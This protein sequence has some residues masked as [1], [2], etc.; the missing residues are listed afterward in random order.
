MGVKCLVVEQLYC[1]K[2]RNTLQ[3]GTFEFM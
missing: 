1:E 2:Q 3:F